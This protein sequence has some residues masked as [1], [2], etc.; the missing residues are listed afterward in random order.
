MLWS[1]DTKEDEHSLLKAQSVSLGVDHFKEEQE[2]KESHRED[3]LLSQHDSFNSLD[4]DAEKKFRPSMHHWDDMTNLAKLKEEGS[5]NNTTETGSST[6]PYR[7]SIVSVSSLE[8]FTIDAHG[9]LNRQFSDFD[10]M[11]S[12]S[13]SNR[14][15]CVDID[16]I[17][18][19]TDTS[20]FTIPEG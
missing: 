5:N 4:L 10:K 3:L 8:S 13:S 9:N 11:K 2:H 12:A 14:S 15:S 7:E 1:G 20:M 18:I 6:L 17:I 16:D 19:N